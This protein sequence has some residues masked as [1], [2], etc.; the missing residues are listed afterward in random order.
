MII[1]NTLTAKKE[2]LV[3]DTD[4][5]RVYVCGPTVYDFAHLGHAR[6]YVIYDILVRHLRAKGYKVVYV[7]N[8]TDIDDKII[9]RA[10]ER[11]VNPHDLA[12]EFYQAYREDMAQL[13]NK[14]PDLEPKVSEHIEQIQNLIQKLVDQEA[15]Y[16]LDGDVYF[17]IDSF[18][19]YGK[20][21]HRNIDELLAGA[22]GRTSTAQDKRKE[23]PGDFA[24][25]KKA[26]PGEPGWSSP[27]GKG[28]PGWHIECSAMSTRYLG[29]SFD[30][31]GGGLDLVFPHHENEIAQSEKASG[32]PLAKIWMHNGFVECNKEKMSKSLGNFFTVRELFDRYEAEAIR[33]LMMTT[34][35]RGP[36]HLDWETD[37]QGNATRFPQIDE[38]ES[39]IEYLYTTLAK[40]GRAENLKIVESKESS[41]PQEL[42][43]LRGA[44]LEQLDADLSLPGCLALISDFLKTANDI[45]DKSASSKTVQKGALLAMQQGVLAVQEVLGLGTDDATHVL[46][47]IRERRARALGVS[48]ERIDRQIEQRAQ[49]RRDGDYALADEIREKL[50]ALRVELLDSPEGTTWKI[51]RT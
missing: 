17:R 30:I 43:D 42:A 37:E 4:T 36:L 29:D 48:P 11:G 19:D 23:N 26:P 47:R 27:W 41:V 38:T 31:H 20:L 25:W 13:G 44:L 40:I 24:L 3:P 33:Y 10:G 32:K 50:Q 46:E 39:R 18:E 12:E 7:R 21:S 15:A 34:A 45:C 14:E 22:S 16:P 28:R 6:C 2:T 8:V 1:F 35:Y 9:K 49:A 5:V 51:T